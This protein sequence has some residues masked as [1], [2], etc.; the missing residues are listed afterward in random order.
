MAA[1]PH[2]RRPGIMALF[3]IM[4][5]VIIVATNCGAAHI[6]ARLLFLFS[7]IGRP[8]G[9]YYCWCQMG[10]DAWNG[11]LLKRNGNNERW[12]W[13]RSEISCTWDYSA[14]V[15]HLSLFGSVPVCRSVLYTIVGLGIACTVPTSCAVCK[16]VGRLVGWARAGGKKV[17]PLEWVENGPGLII[18]GSRCRGI[19][20]NR[21]IRHRPDTVRKVGGFFGEISWRSEG[22]R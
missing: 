17:N 19:S 18:Y 7:L 5:I 13:W 6:S 15:K 14:G 16:L 3:M 12:W 9:S 11:K 4:M 2:R 20:R 8:L 10:Y 21:S 1:H 22:W